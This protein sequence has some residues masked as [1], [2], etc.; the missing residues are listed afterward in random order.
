MSA[1][2]EILAFQI[3]A[4]KLPIPER[5]YKFHPV[6]KWR[7]DFAWPDRL[8][9]VEVEGGTWSGGRHTRGQGFAND[10]LK[11]NQ[12]VIDGWRLLRFTSD[13]IKSGDALKIIENCIRIH[14]RG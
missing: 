14:S 13:Q 10:C 6:R 3:K 2:E 9:L 5:E 1:I 12:A 11:Y 4:A 8:L 7:S